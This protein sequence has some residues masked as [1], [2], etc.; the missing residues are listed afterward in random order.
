[1][2]DRV[3]FWNLVALVCLAVGCVLHGWMS[4]GSYLISHA[5]IAWVAFGM[6]SAVPAG[7]QLLIGFINLRLKRPFARSWLLAGL[8]TA[9]V[10]PGLC[11][12]SGA[13][14]SLFS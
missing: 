9:M 12:V 7:M 4:K 8:I 3:L 6:T 14:A 5:L 11:G 13:A 10:G 2:K 1:M